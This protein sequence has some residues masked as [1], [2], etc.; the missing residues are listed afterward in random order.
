KRPVVRAPWLTAGAK[1]VELPLAAVNSL[2]ATARG[3]TLHGV[4]LIYGDVNR[5]LAQLKIEQLRRPEDPDFWTAIPPHAVAIQTG[6]L[7]VGKGRRTQ[8]TGSVV[9]D[10][11]YATI[12]TVK[13]EKALLA[14]ARALRPA[15]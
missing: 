4:V 5:A 2:T 1:V 6:Q 8:W 10:G 12:E 3:R 9:K 13:G 7:G 14:V 11:V 15:G